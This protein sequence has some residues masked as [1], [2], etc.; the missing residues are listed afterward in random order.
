MTKGPNEIQFTA[1]TFHIPYMWNSK[2]YLNAIAYPCLCVCLLWW[3][4]KQVPAPP[5]PPLSVMK[6]G[7]YDKVKRD[8][9]QKQD[10]SRRGREEE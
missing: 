6:S 3:V 1:D 8:V 9:V 4:I 10:S 2:L 5:P 7:K